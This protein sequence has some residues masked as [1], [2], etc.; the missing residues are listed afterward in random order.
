MSQKVQKLKSDSVDSSKQIKH[1]QQWLKGADIIPDSIKET[2]LNFASDEQDLIVLQSFGGEPDT[3]RAYDNIGRIVLCVT[4]F[5][6]A[7]SLLVVS[8]FR[9][10]IIITAQLLGL[11]V[12]LCIPRRG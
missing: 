5:I 12:V 6:S 1:F 7:L 11:T 10:K 9:I 8:D 2:L 4:L 3:K